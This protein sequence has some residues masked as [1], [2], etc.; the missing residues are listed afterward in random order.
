MMIAM[1]V[2][3]I[4]QWTGGH[5]FQACGGGGR[6]PVQYPRCLLEQEKAHWTLQ[7]NNIRCML[8]VSMMTALL[9]VA[10]WNHRFLY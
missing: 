6:Y 1:Y 4:Q 9:L 8:V 2:L 7:S 3:S 5:L 10:E